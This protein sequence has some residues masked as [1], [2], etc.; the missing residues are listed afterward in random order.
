MNKSRG[1]WYI[2]FTWHNDFEPRGGTTEHEEIPLE[3]TTKNAA[4]AEAHAVVSSGKNIKTSCGEMPV[5][6]DYNVIY[7][8]R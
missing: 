6:K 4:I 5:P 1:K 8:T 7:K 2:S 3:A